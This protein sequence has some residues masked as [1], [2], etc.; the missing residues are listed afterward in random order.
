MR[1]EYE[2]VAKRRLANTANHGSHKIHPD[3]L[4]RKAHVE[5]E[6][7]SRVLDEFFMSSYG[8]ILVEYFTQWLRTEPHETKTR[9]FL[10]SCAMALGSVKEQLVRQ[11]MY[12]K[13]V[14]VMDEMKHKEEADASEGED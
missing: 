2:E 1:K 10:Y 11:E 6:F 14:P 8:E 9:E 4:A 12:G 3:V 13:N 5:S 7:T